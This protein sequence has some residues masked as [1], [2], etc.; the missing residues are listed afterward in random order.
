MNPLNCYLGQREIGIGRPNSLSLVVAWMMDT[1]MLSSAGWG[2]L[3][4]GQPGRGMATAGTS[5]GATRSASM[6][7]APLHQQVLNSREYSS[8]GH[9]KP[10]RNSHTQVPTSCTGLCM[11]N[12]TILWFGGEIR[13]FLDDNFVAV[14][15]LNDPD[16]APIAH[17]W[18]TQLIKLTQKRTKIKFI[19]EFHHWDWRLSLRIIPG[20]NFCPANDSRC[21]NQN[22]ASEPF[23]DGTKLDWTGQDTHH[24]S[25]AEK[26]YFTSWECKIS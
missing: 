21:C 19:E 25:D 24:E 10:N 17:P 22:L 18:L 1:G 5:T 20:T 4:D 6:N 16:S 14:S 7:L 26:N 23:C 8:Y 12:T 11:G 9:T 2:R 3:A 15:A 13:K